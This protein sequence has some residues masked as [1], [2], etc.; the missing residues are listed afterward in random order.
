MTAKNLRLHPLQ[1][2]VERLALDAQNLRG[3][4]LIAARGGE[5]AA[6]LLFLRV[7]QRLDGL[8]RAASMAEARRVAA[9]RRC[10]RSAPE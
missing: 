5:H 3:A 2:A 10:D 1:L 4:A 9:S 7:G 8:L 6:D